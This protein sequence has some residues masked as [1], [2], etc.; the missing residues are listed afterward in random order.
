MTREQPAAEPRFVAD[1]MLGRLARW[2]RVLGYDTLYD[3]SWSDDELV[4]RA[5]AENRVLLTRDVA[6]SRRRGLRTLFVNSDHVEEQLR[7]VA[8]EL[9]LEAER[10]FSRCPVCNETLEAV[11]KSWAWGY[12]PPYTFCTQPEFRLCPECNRFY[13]RGT[14]W[15]RM[16]EAL[17]ELPGAP[18]DRHSLER[19]N[20]HT[21]KED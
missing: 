8:S 7:Q 19:G 11:P 3:V 6:L 14:H 12:V 4:R 2:L 16:R 20:H 18:E 21:A 15:E 13:W 17:C 1:A 10:A 5:R 9:G